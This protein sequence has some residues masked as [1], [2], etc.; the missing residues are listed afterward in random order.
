MPNKD[1]KDKVYL[2][3]AKLILITSK[4]I[5]LY[6]KK[7]PIVK[8]SLNQLYQHL[9]ILLKENSQVT[10]FVGGEELI[11]NDISLSS[12]L[13]GSK[14]LVDKMRELEIDSISFKQG[15]ELSELADLLSLLSIG[16]KLDK[17][18]EKLKTTFLSNGFSHIKANVVHYE[19]VEEGQ[20]VTSSVTKDAEAFLEKKEKIKKD[21]PHEGELAILEQYLQ[22]QVTG[23]ILERHKEDVISKLLSEP[24]Q[25]ANIVVQAAVACG[26]LAK[27]LAKLRECI[28]DEF[29]DELIKKKRKPDRILASLERAIVKSIDT[30]SS[31][32]QIK[33]EID[34]L[35]EI[36]SGFDDNLKIHMLAKIYEV[37]KPN[38]NKFLQRSKR[39]I[40]DSKELNRVSPDL[41]AALIEKGA[42]EAD[43]DVLLAR[44]EDAIESRK[45]ISIAKREYEELKNKA[46]LFDKTLLDEIAKATQ[47]LKRKNKRLAG[48]KERV[49]T[50]IRNLADGMIVVDKQGKVMMI[51]PAAE[52]LLGIDKKEKIGKFLQEGLGSHQLVALAKGNLADEAEA[53]S[54]EIEL[55]S[56]DEQTKRILRAS[57]AVV[58]NENGN[59]VGMVM[60]LSDITRQKQVDKMKSDFVAHVSHELRTPIIATKKSL[61]LL[62]SKACGDINEDQNKFLNIA[63]SNLS[64]LSRLIDDIL[65]FSK[66]EAGKISINPATFNLITL[67]QEVMQ[68]LDTWVK[69]KQIGIDLSLGGKEIDVE[70]DRDKINQVLTNLI[71]NA[72][73]FIAEKGKIIISCKNI[74]AGSG[75][76]SFEAVEVGIT[77]N[78]IGIEEKDCQR[79]FDK[80]EQVSLISPAGV[81]GTGLGLHICKQIV[82]LH[83]GKIWVKSEIGKGS[84]FS[85]TLPKKFSTQ[86]KKEVKD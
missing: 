72:L 23:E 85:F 70:A 56:N 36:I 61:S 68:S 74:T 37:T 31:A 11:L 16:K 46:K 47:D 52:Q 73:K 50:V 62:I 40:I 75:G 24:S 32:S 6:S 39:L 55:S 10:I 66:L 79:I 20:K 64:R 1:K 76:N 77:D 29:S 53:V 19:K 82:E 2:E 5:A 60:M 14:E 57:T 4:K 81:G 86:E 26:S 7:H 27:V 58:E 43:S 3:V 38:L 48:E 63:N 65:D 71:G 8:E 34:N 84:T 83:K 69:D 80:F 9:T 78:G 51:N 41:K 28:I 17:N 21:V 44:L 42:K 13:A 54:K 25:L 15:M 18:E 49:D 30:D 35:H 12:T 45:K 22:G 59:T 33:K 67:I